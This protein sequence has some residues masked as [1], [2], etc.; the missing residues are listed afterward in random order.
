M[1]RISVI[2]CFD[3]LIEDQ[4]IGLGFLDVEEELLLIQLCYSLLGRLYLAYPGSVFS[5]L[6][7]G[8]H[9]RPGIHITY[10]NTVY[11]GG[12][13]LFAVH[14]KQID[15]QHQN[16]DTEEYYDENVLL[17]LF[18]ILLILVCFVLVGL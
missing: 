9:G 10:R 1:I 13:P 15:D 11:F 17:S 4:G 3:G 7:Q 8:V 18:I 6:A 5:S 16:E 2:D 12:H 14:A